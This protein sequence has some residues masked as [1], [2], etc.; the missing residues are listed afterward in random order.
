M[1]VWSTYRSWEPKGSLIYRRDIMQ[2]LLERMKEAK[3]S[4][5][6]AFDEAVFN[7][8]AEEV[9]YADGF[10]EGIDQMIKLLKELK[11]EQDAK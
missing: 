11:E 9:A 5:Y 2:E 8:T 6:R 7:G 1:R 4:A 3:D 10:I